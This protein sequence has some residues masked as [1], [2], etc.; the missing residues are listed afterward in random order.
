MINLDIIREF[1]ANFKPSKDDLLKRIYWVRGGLVP[2]D[3]EAIHEYLEDICEV[4][5]S[6]LDWFAK[7]IA[8]EIGT[9]TKY[10]PTFAMKK[11]PMKWA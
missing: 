9:T 6:K 5:P 11:N 7:K 1:F 8:R 2:F 10:R 3:R 4:D